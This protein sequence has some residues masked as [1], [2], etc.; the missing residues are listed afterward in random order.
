MS[1]ADG[2][3]A[4]LRRGSS[5]SVGVPVFVAGRINQPQEAEAL[6]ADGAA[7]VVRH[8]PR[9]DLRSRDAD[10]RRPAR[11]TT[12]APASAATR[13]ASATSTPATPISCIQHPE[14][15]RELEFGP[16]PRA[17][18]PRTVLVVG[19]GPAGMKAAA[20]AAECGHRVALHEATRRLGGQVLLAQLLPDRAEFGGMVA[21]LRREMQLAGVD[22]HLRTAVGRGA[23]AAR[24]AGRGGVRHRR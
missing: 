15:G 13:P 1:L 22:V 9:P 16:R 17:A 2:Y 7:D 12:S 24:G 3:V 20:V 8:D 19:G 4:P 10:R 18:A 23:V 21:N 6:L 5:E 14:T 11:S